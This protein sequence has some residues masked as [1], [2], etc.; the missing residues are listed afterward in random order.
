[1][2]LEK[3][4][5]R[6]YANTKGETGG[7]VGVIMLEDKV[8]AV[9]AQYPVSGIDF[10]K[11]IPKYTGKP[12]TH[13]LL[14]HIHGDH[15]FGSQAFEDCE[16]ISQIRLKRKVMEN[17][18]TVWAPGKL[19]EMLEDVKINRPERA[20]L[21]EG[22]KIVLPDLAFK[23]KITVD[24]LD[25]ISLPGHTDCS[26]IVY[27]K[28]DK[29]IFAGDL[30]FAKTFPWAGDPTA[31]PDD[32]IKA[33]KIL[34]DMDVN[35]FIPGHGPICTKEEFKKQLSWF[36]AVRREMNQ[37]IIEG[38]SK[39]EAVNYPGYP[40]FYESEGDRR[41]RSLERWYDYWSSR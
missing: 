23:K 9:D 39:E 16:I 3:V 1:M 13:L 29:V 25:M 40:R 12:V 36:E 28:K 14:T 11:S 21:F 5:E 7:N 4:S 22:L 38:A 6:V 24:G 20:Y 35:T 15:I 10:R 27:D 2:D 8:I 34:L 18:E 41:E 30:M 17:L 37:L 31:N 26:S 32:W 33:F 19:E